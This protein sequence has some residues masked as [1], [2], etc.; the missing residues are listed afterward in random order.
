LDSGKYP[1]GIKVS[2]QELAAMNMKRASFH[3]DWN[4]MLL[5]KSRK[6]T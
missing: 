4:Y 5:P 6:K 2:D 3:D 1:T